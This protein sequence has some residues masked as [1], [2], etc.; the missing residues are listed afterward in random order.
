[1]TT[2]TTIDTDLVDMMSAVFARHRQQHEPAIGAARWDTTLWA[3]LDELGL[4]RL[5]GSE[6]TGG[7]GG[8]WLEAAE[9][10]QAAV[11]NGVRVPVAEHDLLAGWLLETAGMPVGTARRTVAV[12]GAYGAASGVP[13]AREAERIV[14]VWHDGNTCRVADLATSAF[15][16]TDG[17]NLAEE[18]RD[19]VRIDLAALSGAAVDESI[20]RQFFLRGAL[21]RALQTCAA[22]DR[23]VDLSVSHAS[24]RSQFGRPLAKFQAVQNL[25]ADIAAEAALARAATEA[26]LAAAVRTQWAATGLEFAVAVARSCAG[27]A[28]SVVVR[29]AHQVHGAIGTTR[30]HRLHE[31]TKPALAWRSEFG[32]VQYWD[33]KL[34]D[35]ALAAGRDGLWGLVTG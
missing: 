13:W 21:V 24:E 35:A 31:F 1:M 30:E 12:L 25:V 23:I 4:V 16:I 18:P 34:T 2:A 28:A 9:L 6:A 7:S 5:T 10:I 33:G 29:N 22:L 8:S 15:E 14:T 19:T 20:V 3:Q 26:A 27:H 17:V 11:C 32:S